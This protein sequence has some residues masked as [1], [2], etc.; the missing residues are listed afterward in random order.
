MSETI[1]KTKEVLIVKIKPEME[2]TIQNIIKNTPK[3]D[4]YKMAKGTKYETILT[5]VSKRP[6][7]FFM[8]KLLEGTEFN[9]TLPNSGELFAF[10]QPKEIGE[11]IFS[12]NPETIISFSANGESGYFF[13]S[14]D[15][16]F[17]KLDDLSEIYGTN[18]Y[19]ISIGEI[20]ETLKSQKIYLSPDLPL[21]FYNGFKESTLKDKMDVLPENNDFKG[22]KG[23][24]KKFIELV[25]KNPKEYG[26]KSEEEYY[27]FKK[28]SLYQ[29]GSMVIKTEDYR[30]FIDG[31]GKMMKREANQNDAIQLINACGIRDFH[32][33][34]TQYKNKEIMTNTFKTSFI[35]AGDGMIVFPAVG[36]GVWRGDPDIYWRS[37]LDAL[38]LS[39]EK[40][41]KVFI[42]PGHQPTKFGKYQGCSGNE[43]GGILKEY[44][45]IYK[46]DKELTDMLKKVVNLFDEQTDV[47]QLAYNLKIAFPDEVV[48]LFN[49]SDPDVTLGNHVGEYT[50]N[51]PHTN[52]TEEN[53]TAMGTNGICFE[54]ITNIHQHPERIIKIENE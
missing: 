8:N 9:F 1:T 20:Q 13:R 32:F 14:Q 21:K 51:C 38:I 52:T 17:Y 19:K 25:D 31:E 40:V 43:F 29:I 33:H 39:S 2:D 4:Y 44:F 18:E 36:M 35:A 37:F 30:I 3:F 27:E 10:N 41:K 23:N 47:V 53:Y 49:A 16:K 24:T 54:S 48:S 46:N 7:T 15:H 26:F 22:L 11:F 28:L 42:V 50:N 6:S 12:E 34:K 45:E 5:G